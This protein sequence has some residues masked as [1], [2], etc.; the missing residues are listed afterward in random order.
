MRWQRACV[1]ASVQSGLLAVSVAISRWAGCC[2]QCAVK[3]LFADI[4]CAA[5]PVLDAVARRRRFA[6]QRL[7]RWRHWNAPPVRYRYV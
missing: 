1:R 5:A 2:C 6:S 7:L 3:H 4:T